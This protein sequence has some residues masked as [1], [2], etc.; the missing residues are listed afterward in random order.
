MR[1][2]EACVHVRMIS[3]NKVAQGRP[4]G[5]RI[6]DIQ[7]GAGRNVKRKATEGANNTNSERGRVG[8]A[9]G[10]LVSLSRESKYPSRPLSSA[11]IKKVDEF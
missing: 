4:V 6:A 10:G 8:G 1:T 9:R 3:P 2:D 7:V 5:H 11:C